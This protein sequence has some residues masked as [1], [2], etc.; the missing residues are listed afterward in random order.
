MACLAAGGSNANEVI[1]WSEA[2]FG[3]LWIFGLALNLA[4][5]SLADYERVRSRRRF[6]VVWAARPFQVASNFGLTCFCL[7]WSGIAGADWERAVWSA[8]GV[9]FAFFTARAWRNKP[10]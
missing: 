5:L 1:D 3:A 7:G 10:I 6:R 4:A 8:L 2:G 9:G